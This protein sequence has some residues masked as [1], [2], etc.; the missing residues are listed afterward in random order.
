MEKM[1]AQALRMVVLNAAQTD[2]AFRR[3]LVGRGAAAVKAKFGDQ[4][5]VRVELEGE[6][7]IALLIPQKTAPLAEALDRVTKSIGT[8][9]P[10]RGE[11]DAMVVHRAWN[12]PAFAAQLKKDA[13]AAVESVLQK[14]GSSVPAAAKVHVYEEKPGESLIVLPPLPADMEELSDAELEAVAGGEAVAVTIVGSVV[15]GV[16]SGVVSAI[17]T[18][19]RALSRDMFGTTPIP[20]F[21]GGSR[22]P[23][24]LGPKPGGFRPV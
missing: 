2:A 10:T 23:G 7:E 8:R 1:S 3:D 17:I 9:P 24:G 4:G 14:Y 12:D 15:G 18:D 19:D 21:I 16:V 20:D 22:R 11:F 6:N 13:R 5:N